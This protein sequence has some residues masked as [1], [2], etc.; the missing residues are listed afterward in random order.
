MGISL[1]VFFPQN[2]VFLI[3]VCWKSEE[4][5]QRFS[6]QYC[7]EISLFLK[8]GEFVM[9]LISFVIVRMFVFCVCGYDAITRLSDIMQPSRLVLNWLQIR[10]VGLMW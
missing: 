5:L 10:Y 4:T 7:T 6:K 2:F 3:I 1:W 9:Y 8:A